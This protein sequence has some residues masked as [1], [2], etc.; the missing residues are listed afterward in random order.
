[1]DADRA[2]RVSYLAAVVAL[3]LAVLTAVLLTRSITEPLR[4][5]TAGTR[6]VARGRF[7]YRLDTRRGDEFAHGGSGF[8]RWWS[9]TVHQAQGRGPRF[10]PSQ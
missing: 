10:T 4:R 7:G 5:L 1:M 6:E 9:F 8:Y 3:L 2:E